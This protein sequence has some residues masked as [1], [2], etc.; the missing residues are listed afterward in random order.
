MNDVNSW[1]PMQEARWSL[2]MVFSWIMHRSVEYVR[3]RWTE[4]REANGDKPDTVRDVFEVAR[5]MVAWDQDRGRS[6]THVEPPE[7]ARTALVSALRS[8]DLIA[9]G[10]PQG[11]P[12][13]EKID[14]EEWDDLDPFVEHSDDAG[15]A[16]AVYSRD[17]RQ[18]PKFLNVRVERQRVIELWPTAVEE[19]TVAAPSERPELP[20]QAVVTL[21]KRPRGP[22]PK[23]ARKVEQAMREYGVE[24]IGEEFERGMK[25]L[26]LQ[27]RFAALAG[28]TT[29]QEVWTRLSSELSE[30]PQQNSDQ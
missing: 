26:E 29:I 25:L 24:R 27:E 4:Y 3:N 13:R 28:P 15:P 12:K 19:K 2:G 20:A 17:D 18:Q 30:F 16:D 10:R 8:G 22:Q 21:P 9:T 6:S 5:L 23:K 7:R 11:H 1:D 14:T